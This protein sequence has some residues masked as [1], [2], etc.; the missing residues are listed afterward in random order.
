M[1]LTDEQLDILRLGSLLHDIGKIGIS[2]AVLRK[3][4]ALTAEEYELIKE[5]PSVGAR[6]LKSIHFL[7]PHVPIVEY[8]HERPDGQGY[9]HHLRGEE[10]PLFARI[11]HVA[12]AFDAM[13]SARA[14]RRARGANDALRELW[15]YA[16]TQFDSDVVQALAL[17]VPT[18]EMPS[19]TI[20]HTPVYIPA[21]RL[22]VVRG[23]GRA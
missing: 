16:G 10:I 13:T 15:R 2:D 7:A 22:A 14:Y 3:P 21:A 17:A 23:L 9:P 20:H 5:H 19:Q 18:L 12:D 1:D 6:I 11:V 8:H 4:G